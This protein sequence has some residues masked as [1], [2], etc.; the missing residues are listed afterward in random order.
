VSEAQL[1]L[2]APSGGDL[3]GLTQIEFT[4]Q[5][6]DGEERD[7]SA[8]IFYP[9][10]PASAMPAGLRPAPYAFPEVIPALRLQA[11]DDFRLDFLNTRTH[12]YPNAPLSDR[13]A[14]YPL[15]I[16]NHGYL[17]H[18]MSNTVLCSDL[19]SHG[20]IVASVSHPG[21]TAAIRYADGRIG[22]PY[23][24]VVERYTSGSAMSPDLV[25]AFE[26]IHAVPEDDTA[27]LIAKARAYYQLSPGLNKRVTVWTEDCMRAADVLAEMNQGTRPSLFTG[28]LR[29]DIGYAAT[30][31]SF[32]G[33]TAAG[34]CHDDARCVCGVNIDGGFFGEYYE[35]D[36]RKPLL[37]LANPHLWKMNQA[38]FWNSSADAFH[39]AVL[40]GTHGGF[41]DFLFTAPEAL[42]SG[43]LGTR[44]PLNYRE[45]VTVAHLRFFETY[46][47]KQADRFDDPGYENTKF[48]AK[49][50]FRTVA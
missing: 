45:L 12:A 38:A 32:G 50:A 43:A 6:A 8:T 26:A 3:V 25:A 44:D 17:F 1:E 5:A 42:A 22:L 24:W 37:T 36:L 39:L 31:H 28:R 47:L 46:L 20:Y 30:G 35:D 16:F 15:V 19:A 10:G 48:Y 29:L 4:C 2:P 11:G 34:L 33:A 27:K 13:Q 49:R 41:T 14:A 9:A 18:E 21:E 23:E 7:I 40:D